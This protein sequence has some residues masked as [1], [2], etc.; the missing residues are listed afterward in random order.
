MR[1]DRNARPIK[2]TH[3]HPAKRARLVTLIVSLAAMVG[4]TATLVVREAL[5][6]TGSIGSPSSASSSSGSST[7]SATSPTQTPSITPGSAVPS[8]NTSAGTPITSSRGS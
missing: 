1:V 7:S 8:T 4:S 3:R 6:T 5:A 2:R